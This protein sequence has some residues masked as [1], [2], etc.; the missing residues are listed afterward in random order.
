MT[1]AQ[2]AKK[3]Q[4]SANII[5]RLKRDEYISVESLKKLC[6]ALDCTVD[7]GICEGRMIFLSVIVWLICRYRSILCIKYLWS[8]M[9][10]ALQKE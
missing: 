10:V 5:T 4:V 3:A 2:L 7:Y 1:T 9:T 8:R 6:N